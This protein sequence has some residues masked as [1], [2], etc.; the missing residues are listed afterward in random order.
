MSNSSPACAELPGGTRVM[1]TPAALFASVANFSASSSPNH[2]RFVQGQTTVVYQAGLNTQVLP[3]FDR[4]IAVSTPLQAQKSKQE[5][6]EIAGVVTT[7]P[8]ALTQEFILQII[9]VSTRLGILTA[10]NSSLSRCIPP[11]PP[12]QTKFRS[13]R[14]QIISPADGSICVPLTLT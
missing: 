14:R 7:S 8:V 13:H 4:T 11:P 1:D 6:E 10:S 9:V 5:S 3:D 2:H 12:H